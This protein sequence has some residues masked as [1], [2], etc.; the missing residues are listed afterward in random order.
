MSETTDQWMKAR[1]RLKNAQKESHRVYEV[2][3]QIAGE[4][5]SW[6]LIVPGRANTIANPNLTALPTMEQINALAAEMKYALMEE[7]NAFNRIPRDEQ[8]RLR[9]EA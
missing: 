2:L 1:M 5:R 7:F 6:S 3:N 8:S 4:L 9:R